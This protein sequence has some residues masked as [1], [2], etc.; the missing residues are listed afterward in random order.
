MEEQEAI[1]LLQQGKVEALQFFYENYKDRIFRLSFSILHNY[2]DAEDAL[3]EIFLRLYTQVSKFHGRASFWTWFY[4]L[5]INTLK[6]L[7]KKRSR[8][9]LHSV[10]LKNPP[11]IVKYP[12]KDEEKE[13]LTKILQGLPL[14]YK[15][16]LMLR[17]IDG[18]NYKDI[19][20]ILVIPVGTV[21]SRL[22]RARTILKKR[23]QKFRE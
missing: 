9:S 1:K 4:R 10:N 16:P 22:S 13:I 8:L 12:S 21:M 5:S 7:F 18:L 15:L 19:A 6:N 17:E 2:Q 23:F 20:E 14:K 3:H 11:R